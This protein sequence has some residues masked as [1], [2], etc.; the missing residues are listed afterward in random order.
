MAVHENTTAAGNVSWSS[1][2]TWSTE[3]SS[4]SNIN[5]RLVAQA[6]IP[7]DT[8]FPLSNNYSISDLLDE[9]ILYGN[10]YRDGAAGSVRVVAGYLQGA[11]Q[12][13]ALKNNLF[14]QTATVTIRV[15]ATYPNYIAGWYTATNKGGT[16]LAAGGTSTTQL[17]LNLTSATHTSVTNFYGYI[18]QGA[19]YSSISLGYNA[20]SAQD[21]CDE[22][23]CGTKNTYYTDGD[24]TTWYND[25]KHLASN[26]LGSTAATAGH[27]SDGTRVRY[28]S[29]TAFT[30]FASLCSPC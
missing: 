3:Y 14:S 26:S 13:F 2:D 22:Y 25:G 6:C 10:V 18:E 12:S 27:Y 21:A 28:W 19:T 15:T 11:S 7:A 1:M 20:T 30:G 23:N 9:P 24:G 8:V 16:Q 29:G 17:D 5:W 4:N